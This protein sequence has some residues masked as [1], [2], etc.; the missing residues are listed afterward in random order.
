R[1]FRMEDTHMTEI[2]KIEKL[3]FILALAFCWAYKTGEIQARQI[4][5]LVKRHGRKAKSIFRLGLNLI[6]SILFKVY[7]R[8]KEF[9]FLLSCFK[10]LKSEVSSI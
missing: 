9:V 8:F 1:G 5:I 2:D 3:V 10:C 7:R 4:P 6:R